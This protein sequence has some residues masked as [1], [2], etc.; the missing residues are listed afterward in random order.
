MSTTPGALPPETWEDGVITT[1]RN[2]RVRVKTDPLKLEF[3]LAIS[4]FSNP[5][6]VDLCNSWMS[7]INAITCVKCNTQ[8]DFEAASGEQASR[9]AWGDTRIRLLFDHLNILD[10]KY[11]IILTF[12]SLL[13]IA[14][15]VLFNILLI[16]LHNSNT[17]VNKVLLYG[18]V[19]VGVLFGILGS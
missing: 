16:V 9:P 10:S 15:N 8:F 2:A 1:L 17:P 12:N 7:H 5:C 19:I 13:L 3:R 6:W 18:F 11:N 4:R 14:F